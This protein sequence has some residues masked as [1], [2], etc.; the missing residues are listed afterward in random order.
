MLRDADEVDGPSAAPPGV[1]YT[2]LVPN[3]RGRKGLEARADELNLVGM[4][5][6]NPQPGQPAHALLAHSFAVKRWCTEVGRRYAI[7]VSLPCAL[8]AR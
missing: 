5:T 7:I 6:R 1:E 3:L 4:S 2:V 8:A